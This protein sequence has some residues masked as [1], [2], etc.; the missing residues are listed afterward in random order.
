MP[1]YGTLLGALNFI[2]EDDRTE[3]NWRGFNFCTVF[4]PHRK[5]LQVFGAEV[6]TNFNDSQ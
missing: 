3:M 5:F 6:Q 2:I 4:L 1:T